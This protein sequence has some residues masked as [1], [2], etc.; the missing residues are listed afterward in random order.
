MPRDGPTSTATTVHCRV[1]AGVLVLS[2][3]QVSLVQVQLLR[4]RAQQRVFGLLEMRVTAATAATRNVTD[5]LVAQ[6]TE[7][8]VLV[9]VGAGVLVAVR[10][11]ARVPVL[12][13]HF[14]VVVVVVDHFA[15]MNERYALVCQLVRVHVVYVMRHF[16]G[17][18]DDD[19]VMPARK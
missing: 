16:F 4:G 7:V 14:A 2:L 10:R 17:H 9:S 6:V 19:S 15:R 12:V 3:L 11:F 18:N 5:V 1:V 8:L 13:R